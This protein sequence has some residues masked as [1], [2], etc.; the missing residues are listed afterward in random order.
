MAERKRGL[1]RGLGALIPDVVTEE[2]PVDVFFP[3][4]REVSRETKHKEHLDPAASMAKSRRAKRAGRGRGNGLVGEDG[5]LNVPAEVLGGPAPIER[6]SEEGRSLEPSPAPAAKRRHAAKTP[7]ER[8]VESAYEE[9]SKPETGSAAQT[10]AGDSTP[11]EDATESELLTVPGTA[12]GLLPVTQIK[13]NPRQPRTVFDEDALA[14]LVESIKAVGVLQPVVVRVVDKQAPSYELIMG[15]RRF[16]ASQEAGLT[17]IPAIIREVKEDDLLRDALLENLHRSDLNPLEEAAAYQQL[18]E[19]F[20]CT[21]EELS[22]RIGRSRPQ[23]SNTL[24]LLK[25]PSLVQRR[26]AAGVISQGHARALLGLADGAG[27]EAL[28]QRIV[29]EGLSVRATEEAVVL[30]NRGEKP[31]AKRSVQQEHPE[32]DSLAA[33]LG[34]RLDTRVNISMGKRKGKLSVEFANQDDLER[35]LKALGITQ[36]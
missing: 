21:Q 29:A 18:L 12:F 34:D 35:I 22:V 4:S 15:E 36:D 9:G 13:P 1:G 31:K 24:R 25:L 28:A 16:R 6:L 26:V 7:V 10:S 17:E 2:R 27:M 8:A 5:K 11:A 20:K 23:I 33:S 3:E 19:D 14:E 30:L 32:L